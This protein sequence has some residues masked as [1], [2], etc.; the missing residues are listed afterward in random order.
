MQEEEEEEKK[1]SKQRD[2]R[3]VT[4]KTWPIATVERENS[5]KARLRTRALVSDK[6]PLFLHGFLRRHVFYFSYRIW[7]SFSQYLLQTP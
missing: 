7:P 6:L 4:W 1:P 5:L 3:T 2:L